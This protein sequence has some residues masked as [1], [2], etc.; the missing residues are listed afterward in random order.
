MKSGSVGHKESEFSAV[1]SQYT[2]LS[3]LLWHSLHFKKNHGS[4]YVESKQE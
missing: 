1:E 4:L 2:D 3:E